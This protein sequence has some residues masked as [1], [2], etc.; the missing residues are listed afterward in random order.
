MSNIGFISTRFHGTDGVS[1][2]AAKWSNTFL[3]L[4]HKTFWFAGLL[5]TPEE[6]SLLCE[7]AFFGHPEVIDL[8]HDLFEVTRRSREVTR[9]I[10]ALKE[11]LKD[12]LY[13]F[14]RRFEIDVL[15]PENILAI[16]MHLALGLAVTEVIA[17]TRI[18]TIAHHHDFAWERQRFTNNAVPDLLATAFPPTFDSQ[19]FRDVVINIPAQHAL[20]RRR[21]LQSTVIPNVFDFENPPAEPDAFARSFREEFGIAEDETL[22]LQP[23][24]I[25]SR[26]GIHH[27][28]DLVARLQDLGRKICLV[29]SHNAGDEGLEYLESLRSDAE[30]SGIR[31]LCI[32]D[33]V[34]ESRSES[35]GGKKI[36]SLWDVFPQADLVTYPSLYEG[37][38]NAFLEAVYFRRPIFVNR[39]AIYVSDIAP[40]GFKTVEMDG[41]VTADHA[42]RIAELLGDPS[43]RDGWADH[44]Y[45]IGLE[46]FS[47]ALLRRRLSGILDSLS[48]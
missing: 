4:G 23:T 45:Q 28:I 35:P 46:K 30:R 16:P 25:V 34:G 6:T 15:V 48:G 14:I 22:V 37:F 27:A 29:I 11:E 7:K 40:A 13:A 12:A 10:H 9:H 38:G 32:G 43:L 33:R 18:P 26:K 41:I 31:L 47:H 19:P 8:Q 21:G 42:K 20:A 3:D 17:E 24:R 1:L 36:F 44:N 5:D 2:E 39:Y